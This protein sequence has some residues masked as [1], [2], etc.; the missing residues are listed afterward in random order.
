MPKASHPKKKLSK[1][2]LVQLAVTVVLLVLVLRKLDS[3]KLVT[4]LER[5]SFS[6]MVL[7][8]VIY[9]VG[10]LISSV[11]WSILLKNA[12]IERSY[13]ETLRAYFLGMFVNSF[14]LGT[15]GGDVARA[16]AL[17]PEQ[18]KRAATFASVIA[19]RIHGLGVLLSIGAVSIA[20]FK[21]AVL[22]PYAGPLALAGS[23]AL[24]V[25]WFI[26]P[27][28]LVM[29]G[30]RTKK[31]SDLARNVARAFPS[32]PGVFLATTSLSIIAHCCQLYMHSLMAT[33][34]Q[35]TLPLSYIFSTIPIANA[36]STLP[37]SVQGLGVRESAYFFLLSPIGIEPEVC[38]AFGALWFLTAQGVSA[39]GALFIAPGLFLGREKVEDLVEQPVETEELASVGN[40]K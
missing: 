7:L 17:K 6:Y 9:L 5:V 27:K 38:V 14:G 34:L 33:A 10:Q 24:L 16:L 29:I 40:A 2:L 13:S 37:I 12:G 22:G 1:K 30:D 28:V 21:P 18:G 8:A 23:F 35:V 11:K 15:V 4:V 25:G 3:G 32:K 39:L 20:I 36:A 31:F 19:D 26:G